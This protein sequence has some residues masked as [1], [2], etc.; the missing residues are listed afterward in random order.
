[1]P[2]HGMGDRLRLRGVRPAVHLLLL[3]TGLDSLFAVPDKAPSESAPPD[4]E[5]RTRALP[6]QRQQHERES[7]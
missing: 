1:M 7:A 6:E 2:T 4:T 5:R 3:L